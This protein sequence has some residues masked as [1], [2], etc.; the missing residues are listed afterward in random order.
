MLQHAVAAAVNALV[1]GP[2]DHHLDIEGADS[3]HALY[4]ASG[5]LV[6]LFEWNGSRRMPG[7][8]EM[9]E[10]AE[11]L[12]VSLAAWLG[13]PGHALQIVFCR[14]PAAAAA[15]VGRAIAPA[16]IQAK[17]LSLE[18]DDIIADRRA[19]LARGGVWERCLVAIYT[20]PAAVAGGQRKESVA[21]ALSSI[22][23]MPPLRDAQLPA[24]VS[25]QMR[26]VH[27][28]LVDALPVDFGRAGQELHLLPAGEAARMIAW[29]LSPA[30][31]DVG[32]TPRLPGHQAGGRPMRALKAADTRAALAG[33]DFSSVGLE[34]LS[35]QLLRS[36]A[37]VV[38][39]I[40]RIGDTI[41]QGF[42]LALTPETVVPFRQLLE[43]V[44]DTEQTIRWRASFLIESGGMHGTAMKRA[45]TTTLTFLSRVHNSRIRDAFHHLQELDGAEET[46]I[47]LR[48]CFA[49]WDDVG[50]EARLRRS[51][52]RLRHAVDRWGNS[53]TDELAGDPVGCLL[54]SVPG[55]GCAPT[56]PAAV[57]PLADALCLLP[58][59]RPASPWR[60]GPMTFVCPDG[61]FFPWQPG[62]PLQDSWTNVISGA[63]GSGKSVLL[64]AMNAATLLSGRGRDEPLPLISIIDIGASS[65]GLVEMV[66]NALPPD[67]RHLAASARLQ[68]DAEWAIN[69]FDTPIGCRRPTILGKTFIVNFLRLMMSGA[70][71][72]DDLAGL[73]GLAVDEAYLE[74][75]DGKR[76]RQWHP[77][78]IP[79]VDAALAETGWEA[80]DSSTWWECVDHLSDAGK[81]HE[82]A[83]AQRMAV[84][85]LSD[86]TTA[87]ASPRL[88][89]I[90]AQMGIGSTGEA[91]IAAFQRVLTETLAEWPILSMPT[92][93]AMS[94]ARLRVIDLQDVTSRSQEAAAIRRSAMM[95][96][97]A[98]HVCTDGYY[99]APD[100]MSA[101]TVSSGMRASQRGRLEQMARAV[102]QTP[103]RLCMDE[104]H[105]A[106]GLPG[107]IDQVETDI[108]EGRKHGVQIALASQLLSDFSDRIASLATGVWICSAG[109]E[110]IEMASRL[111]KLDESSRHALRHRLTGPGAG[112]APVFAA[113]DVKGGEVRQLLEHRLG[114]AEIWAYSTTA[115]DVALREELSRL[116]GPV[117]ARAALAA[118]WPTGTA[119]KAIQRLRDT[120]AG[121]EVAGQAIGRLAEDLASR[122][123]AA[124]R[125]HG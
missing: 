56:A 57:A 60:S 63:P 40:V 73:I 65:S 120:A 2:L 123:Q 37:E 39:S 80:D 9:S 81:W 113:L 64:N 33:A 38:S 27:S 7:E 117:Q 28:A 68:N 119:R 121:Q 104:F 66:R 99:L 70:A 67:Q 118:E 76:P 101:L 79:K 34:R 21:E 55:G 98:R 31:G 41:A 51:V 18:L 43:Q 6:S 22:S 88:S 61:R 87:A 35:W 23:G 10:S 114:A 15:D 72:G 93:F 78:Q 116:I 11:R 45:Y 52:A 59:D 103:K 100:E 44:A 86:L 83:L 49:C 32:Y 84:P 53:R 69:I 48:C 58:L 124:G 94:G 110:D 46:I 54:A 115:E 4:S 8:A 102:Q 97:L 13:S 24:R 122:H 89:D 96:L 112:G 109:P 50:Q 125:V 30:Q 16:E 85:L 111:L 105:R 14:D 42:D 5:S 92:V 91:A 25:E 36:H 95:Y 26:L 1:K 29:A 19:R 108:R 47:R 3:E 74:A 106:G 75:S 17:A 12:R 77:D 71:G 90:Y 62:S 20:H 107:I 82:A